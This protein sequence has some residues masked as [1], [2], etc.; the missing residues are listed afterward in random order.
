MFH[1]GD[2]LLYTCRERVT[3]FL[4]QAPFT[5]HRLR[6]F[7]KKH[8]PPSGDYFRHH[9]AKVDTILSHLEDDTSRQAFSDLL[10]CRINNITP[11]VWDKTPQYFPQDI[12]RLSSEEVFVDCGAYTGD[13][14]ENFLKFTENKYKKIVAFEPEPALFARLKQHNFENCTCINKGVW[15]KN[16]HLPFLATGSAG[17]RLEYAD[18]SGNCPPSELISIPVCKIDEIPACAGAT[19]LKMDVEGAELNALKGA[20]KTI[21]KNKPK[22]AIC[23]YHSDRDMLEIPLWVLS[24][25]LG[26]RLYVRHYSNDL[27]ETVLYAF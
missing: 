12:L 19:F 13:T 25:R 16:A 11:S 1:F 6:T 4:S 22:L 17:S 7:A 24:L 21:L 20:Q 18:T 5:P 2:R 26:Y 15:H 14:I 9:Q 10:R 8:F 23:I 27:W 3:S